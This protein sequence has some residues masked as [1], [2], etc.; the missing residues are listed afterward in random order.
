MLVYQRV[1]W[2]SL[3]LLCGCLWHDVGYFHKTAH[4]FWLSSSRKPRLLKYL[5]ISNSWTINIP[6]IGSNM[7]YPTVVLL[8]PTAPFFL[9]FSMVK[10]MGSSWFQWVKLGEAYGQV[11]DIK[12]VLQLWVPRMANLNGHWTVVMTC[13]FMGVAYLQTNSNTHRIHGAG[14]YGKMDPINISPMLAYIPYMDPMGYTLMIN[15]V[16]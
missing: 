6:D 8:N 11:C 13:E 4:S 10:N 1:T 3:I 15:Y 2:D 7:V 5:A 9:W 14:I 16:T 12:K